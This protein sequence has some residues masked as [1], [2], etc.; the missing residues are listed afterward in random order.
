[1]PVTGRACGWCRRPIS[2]RARRDAKWCSK[3]CRQAAHRAS[4]DRPVATSAATV[5]RLAY[6]DPPYVG[7]ARR[8]YG[9][10]ASYAGE[11]DHGRLLSRLATFD[12]WALSCSSSSIPFL[13]GLAYELELRPVPRLAIWHKRPAPHPTA[14]LVTAYE[15][16]L[17]VPARGVAP[18]DGG[19]ALSDVLT[20]VQPRQRPTLPGG[21]ITGTK[22]PAFCTW[23]FELLGA[24][25]GDELEDMYPGSGIVARTWRAWSRPAAAMLDGSLR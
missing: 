8:Y 7:L 24:R 4:I 11:V 21:Q 25:P 3:S 14:R 2:P 9:R 22:P 23:L 16:V 5:A 18:R 10:E 6:A 1:M 15:G 20:G 13:L 19:P 12:G 17:Y